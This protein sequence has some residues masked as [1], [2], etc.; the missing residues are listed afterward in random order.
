MLL[1]PYSVTDLLPPLPV[2]AIHCLK[3]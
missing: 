3:R 2:I 1:R